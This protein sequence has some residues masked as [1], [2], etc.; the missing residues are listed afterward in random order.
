MN[1]SV[2]DQFFADTAFSTQNDTGA[3]ARHGLNGLVDLLHGGAGADEAEKGGATFDLLDEAAAFELQ[4]A[5]FN[6][7]Q[8]NDFE[9]VIVER[10]EKEFVS[11][12]LAGF[13]G[14][15]T[16]VGFREGDNDDVVA[17]LADFLEYFQAIDGTVADAIEIEEDGV[18]A[19]E[20]ENGFDFV[21]GGGEGGAEFIA[22]M[23]ANFREGL[24]VIGNDS[25]GVAL[26]A[27]GGFGQGAGSVMSGDYR[28]GE[29]VVGR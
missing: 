18:E 2:G 21:F 26:H 27:G 24:G 11:A 16:A 12:G 19:G 22:E 25:Q 13:Q 29:L 1:N 17:N 28:G 7:A 10:E 23:P 5:L 20:F 3:G 4:R 6:G 14:N 9:F 8:E 15:G